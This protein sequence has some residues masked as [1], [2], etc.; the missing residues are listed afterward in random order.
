MNNQVSLNNKKNKKNNKY[1]TK[2]VCKAG[3]QNKTYPLH[4]VF[5]SNFYRPREIQVY[6]KRC[7]SVFL[8]TIFICTAQIRGFDVIYWG[9]FE[10]AYMN[11]YIQCFFYRSEVRLCSAAV[12]FRRCNGY[13]KQA[14]RYLQLYY[15][16][17]KRVRE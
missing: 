15:L 13:Y 8:F 9:N 2:I 7:N 6:G 3:G 1:I 4:F 17:L 5:L 16:F 14:R 10:V 12:D 11:I